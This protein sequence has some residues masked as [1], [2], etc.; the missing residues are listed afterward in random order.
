MQD[1]MVLLEG[2]MYNQ[3]FKIEDLKI[4]KYDQLLLIKF[5]RH[6]NGET[7]LFSTN[8][9]RNIGHQYGK[10]TQSIFHNLYKN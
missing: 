8:I 10:K 4:K 6:F 5:Q 2:Y 1:R 9:A 3:W 7:M